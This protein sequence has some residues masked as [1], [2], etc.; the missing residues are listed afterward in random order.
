LQAIL[1]ACTS[2]LAGLASAKNSNWL[3]C[4]I[5][6]LS[7]LQHRSHEECITTRCFQ[8]CATKFSEYIEHGGKTCHHHYQC[9]RQ[10]VSPTKASWLV[11]AVWPV[12]DSAF[13]GSQNSCPKPSQFE[14]QRTNLN[15]YS[16]Y[17]KV[18]T[19]LN[20]TE[21]PRSFVQIYHRILKWFVCWP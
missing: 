1:S 2:H 18:D 11:T 4:P 5:H 12:E 6:R 3:A 19:C 16:V 21:I 17:L 20:W 13:T 7:P 14:G 9:P 10:V 15:P 8:R